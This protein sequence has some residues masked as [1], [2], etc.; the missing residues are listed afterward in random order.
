MKG[1]LYSKLGKT[2]DEKVSMKL[3]IIQ[4]ILIF[5]IIGTITS[6]LTGLVFFGF[7][8]FQLKSTFFQFIIVGL[9]CSLSFILF[10][11]KRYRDSVFILIII[12]LFEYMWVGSKYPITHFIYFLSV[13]ICA[14]IYSKY[15]Y[16]QSQ[17]VKLSRP[18]ILSSL[19]ALIFV[20]D[21]YILLLIYEAGPGKLLPFKNMP[22]GFLT[23]LGVGIG[24]EVSEYLIFRIESN[25]RQ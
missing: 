9:I 8:I 21:Y 19:M 20:I 11:L 23:G 14:F 15:F 4:K 18:L 6:T 22:I 1:F 3:N 24:I 12:F 16:I 5:T 2:N 25:R 7:E 17:Q 10:K 13:I